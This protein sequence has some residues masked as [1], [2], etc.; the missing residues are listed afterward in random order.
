M[1]FLW[2]LYSAYLTKEA[3][4]SLTDI[5]TD[6]P[7]TISFKFKFTGTVAPRVYVILDPETKK[8]IALL[9]NYKKHKAF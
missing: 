4:S 9:K 1:Y 5:S 2:Y 7:E 8:V 3:G 6:G